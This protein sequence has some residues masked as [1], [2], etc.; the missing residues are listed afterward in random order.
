MQYNIKQY[1]AAGDPWSM[2]GRG[3]FQ[4]YFLDLEGVDGTVMTNKKAGNTPKLGQ[5]EGDLI[6]QG[7]LD[8]RGRKIYKFKQAMGSYGASNTSA[9]PTTT[10]APASS[11]G[12]PEWFAPYAVMIKKMYDASLSAAPVHPE[13]VSQSE[14]VEPTDKY[15]GSGFTK[16]ELEDIFGGEMEPVDPES[17]E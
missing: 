1:S 15:A 17:G 12:I 13:S 16:E 8:K 14:K 11:A 5:V 3:E 9:T 10:Q 7:K 2:P 6:D 4:T